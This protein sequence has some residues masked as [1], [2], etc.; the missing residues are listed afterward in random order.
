MNPT[1]TPFAGATHARLDPR[2]PAQPIKRGTYCDQ[3]AVGHAVARATVNGVA[4]HFCGHHFRQHRAA[5][6]ANPSIVLHEEPVTP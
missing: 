3:C 5:L 1:T 2:G 6:E 4:L